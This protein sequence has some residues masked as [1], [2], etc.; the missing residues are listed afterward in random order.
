MTT[1][2]SGKLVM[3]SM[4]QEIL[5]H[6]IVVNCN[7]CEV[8]YTGFYKEFAFFFLFNLT[9]NVNS[10]PATYLLFWHL[11]APGFW[12]IRTKCTLAVAVLNNYIATVYVTEITSYYTR[13]MLYKY[14]TIFDKVITFE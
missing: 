4:H 3:H 6:D 13:L 2:G 10:F 12:Y 9:H 5:V 7:S 14:F 11:H 1:L 8:F